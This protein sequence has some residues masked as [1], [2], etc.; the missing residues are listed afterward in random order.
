MWLK[1]WTKIKTELGC[2]MLFRWL[3]QCHVTSIPKLSRCAFRKINLYL[4]WQ[5]QCER[6]T[7][8]LLLNRRMK[9][10]AKTVA[11]IIMFYARKIKILS[12]TYVV[13]KLTSRIIY[14]NKYMLYMLYF[15]NF[16][17]S[18]MILSVMIISKP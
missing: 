18:S 10:Y 5:I 3:C 13:I 14:V 15:M 7:L 17:L 12:E 1:K 4:S 6:N 9:F 2:K 11:N 8:Q 16:I